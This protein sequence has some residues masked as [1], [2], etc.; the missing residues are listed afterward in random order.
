MCRRAAV[1]VAYPGTGVINERS[2]GSEGL[3]RLTQELEL[4]KTYL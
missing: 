3:E 4:K 1:Q 2:L